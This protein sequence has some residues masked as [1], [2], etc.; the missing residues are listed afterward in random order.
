MVK[1]SSIEQLYKELEKTRILEK[2]QSEKV[3]KLRKELEIIKILEAK[4]EEKVEKLHEEKK[5]KK[6]KSK[7][8]SK[9]ILSKRAKSIGIAATILAG[10]VFTQPPNMMKSKK[11]NINDEE[12]KKE[13]I[14]E[15]TKPKSDTITLKNK[16]EKI[17]VQEDSI[18]QQNMAEKESAKPK[19][20][21][22]NTQLIIQH[23]TEKINED[24]SQD[25][26]FVLIEKP[27]PN[28][29]PNRYSSWMA[30]TEKEKE[31]V[32]NIYQQAMKAKDKTEVEK[33][34]NQIQSLKIIRGLRDILVKKIYM[35]QK[36]K[37][38]I[39]HLQMIGKI[40][41]YRE[42]ALIDQWV[43]KTENLVAKYTTDPSN[44]TIANIQWTSHAE[45]LDNAASTIKVYFIVQY[46]GKDIGK[47]SF[48]TNGHL[49]TKSLKSDNITYNLSQ[50]GSTIL[51]T[52]EYRA[53]N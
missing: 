47:I 19:E 15:K 27:D 8:K 2:Q 11:I 40:N 49:L 35:H 26:V 7:K 50:N 45:Y 14:K 3:A 18:Q 51:I 39:T 53:N 16:T 37:K 23:T 46:W 13:I 32:K 42:L 24:F 36:Q 17:I 12:Q 10:V 21:Q 33:V 41:I 34:I 22:K 48:D 1:R 4:Q 38:D 6:E 52:E 9:K 31:I 5:N 43:A 20:E 29:D 44:F 30:L 28:I 25:K